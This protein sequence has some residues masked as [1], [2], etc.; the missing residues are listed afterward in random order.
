MQ[1]TVLDSWNNQSITSQ[2]LDVCFWPKCAHES[3]KYLQDITRDTTDHK[4]FGKKHLLL[5]SNFSV[6]V[7]QISHQSYKEVYFYFILHIIPWNITF[8][9]ST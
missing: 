8:H 7:K 6:S 5:G 1:G 3:P 9:T 4:A 2:C